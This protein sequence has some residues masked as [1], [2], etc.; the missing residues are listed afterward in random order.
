M[1]VDEAQLKKTLLDSELLTADQFD[2]AAATA[3]ERNWSL[4]DTLIKEDYLSSD[5]LGQVVA[6][7]LGVPFVNLVKTKI[8][9]RTLRMVP[10]LVAKNQ[11]AIA[12]GRDAQGV[13]VALADPDNLELIEL[14]RKRIGEPCTIVYA[15]PEDIRIALKYYHKGLKEEFS[16][17][18][19]RHISE[20]KGAQAEDIPIIKIVDT[21]IEYAYENHA[22]DIHIEPH[23]ERIVTRFRIDGI[24]HDAATLPKDILDSVVTRIK[25]LASLRT[26]EHRSAQDGRF[27]KQFQDEKVDIRVSIVPISEGEKIV[28]RLLSKGARRFNLEELGLSARD[29]DTLKENIQRPHGMTLSTGPTGSGKTTTLYAVLK[30]LNTRKVN[31]STIEDPVEYDIEGIN[32]IQVNEAT[33]LTFAHGL[34]SILRQDPDIIMVGEIRD[35]DTAGIAINAAMTGHV[36]LSTLHTNDAATTLPRLL[37]MGIEPFLISSTINIAIGQRLVRRIHQG[38]VESYIPSLEEVNHIQKILGQEV[39]QKMK[40]SRKELRLYRGRGCD[41]CNGTG[42]EGRIG[43]FEILRMSDRIRQLVM[44]H[45]N[46]DEIRSAAIEEGMIT[47]FQDGINKV[48]QGVTTLEEILRVTQE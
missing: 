19:S 12:Y 44:Q 17:I 20:A 28:L 25:I 35:E 15:T 37:D 7:L 34:R 21:L 5:H 45:A 24:L 38:C 6:D 14:L 42:F 27:Q 47:M 9:E 13:N 22:S 48:L 33:N 10:E 31:I 18:L 26:D 11:L 46:S 29:L 23:D 43:I 39:L 2:Q 40:V 3:A 8:D 36:V 16:S 30:M 41:V 32:Q 4:I 1:S